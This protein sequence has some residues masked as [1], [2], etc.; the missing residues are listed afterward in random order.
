MKHLLLWALALSTAA[1][2]ATPPDLDSLPAATSVLLQRDGRTLVETYARG[3]DESTLHDTRSVTKSLTALTVAAAV[4]DGLLAW[5]EPVFHHFSE[6]APFAHDGP[7]KRGITVGDLLTM[8][9]ALDCND[10]DDGSPG[11]E[12]HMYPQREW[13]RWVLDLPT[14]HVQRDA[15][16][17]QPFAYCTAGVFLLGQLLERRAP[18]GLDAYQA[19]RLF[20]PLG[21][22][23]WQWSRSPSGEAMTGGGLRLSTRDLTRI[24]QMLLQQGSPVLTPDMVQRTLRV[25]RDG[26]RGMGYG[27]LMWQ[28]DFKTACGP[29]RGWL[30]AGNG[31]NLVA[32]FIDSQTSVVLTR[33]HYN[34]RQMHEQSWAF[35]EALL[36]RH[37]CGR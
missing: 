24:A 26:G 21:I 16:G 13:L 15:S 25:Q 8:S 11:N 28:R 30:M 12:E 22:G 18:G 3:A 9:S 34:Q 7:A 17:R 27:Q 1:L 35:V 31:G 33:T 19:R 2:G 6:R 4:Q 23:R 32:V 37:V 5:D 36:D 10:W 20:T 29:Q 14:R